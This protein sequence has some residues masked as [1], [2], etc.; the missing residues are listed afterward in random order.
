MKATRDT[1]FTLRDIINFCDKHGISYDTPIGLAFCDEER[2]DA[3]RGIVVDTPYKTC[4]Y[5][6]ETD[7]HIATE[8]TGEHCT[9]D[10]YSLLYDELS[11][12]KEAMQMIMLTD[13][14][15]Y[16]DENRC[17]GHYHR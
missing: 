1:I 9:C 6:E 4:P 7:T 3:C 5:D 2:R 8:I 15:H 16:D 11:G 12:P 14:C 17:D 10:G 13:G